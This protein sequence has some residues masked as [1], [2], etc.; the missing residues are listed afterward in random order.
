MVLA[1]NP[2]NTLGRRGWKQWR[3]HAV[4]RSRQTTPEQKQKAGLRLIPEAVE[5]QCPFVFGVM[6]GDHSV[7]FLTLKP[8]HRWNIEPGKSRSTTPLFVLKPSSIASHFTVHS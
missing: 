2:R 7:F 1:I 4:P 3:F 6:F 5:I 8:N